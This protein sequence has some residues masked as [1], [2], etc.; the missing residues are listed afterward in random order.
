MS[1]LYKIETYCEEAVKQIADCIEK[2]GGKCVTLG[3]AL[4]TDHIFTVQQTDAIMHLV[5]RTTDQLSEGDL[6]SWLKLARLVA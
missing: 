3:W 5:S 2:S 4:I 1:S 6:N